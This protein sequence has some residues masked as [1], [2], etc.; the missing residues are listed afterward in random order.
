MS[1]LTD[2]TMVKEILP[3]DGRRGTDRFRFSV[4]FKPGMPEEQID[5]LKAG[6]PPFPVTDSIT[7]TDTRERREPHK[8]LIL[9]D[10]RKLDAMGNDIILELS[11]EDAK[12]LSEW[13]EHNDRQP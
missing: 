8:P 5:W 12:R 1:N 9:H 10:V 4:F 6:P 13:L 2:D 3:G 7:V 11:G